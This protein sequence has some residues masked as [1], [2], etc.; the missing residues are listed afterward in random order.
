M[1]AACCPQGGGGGGAAAASSVAEVKQVAGGG[2]SVGTG[3]VA[4]HKCDKLWQIV[5]I[6]CLNAVPSSWLE[7]GFSSGRLDT[8]SMPTL[9]C[10]LMHAFLQLGI[11]VRYDPVTFFGHRHKD[12]G[13][14]SDFAIFD[15][16][17][18]QVGLDP[19]MVQAGTAMRCG[20]HRKWRTSASLV[21]ARF[22]WT[23]NRWFPSSSQVTQV[24]VLSK[25]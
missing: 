14:V 8:F 20:V 21:N 25:G 17:V 13:S 9:D 23:A 19:G 10:P 24:P 18:W 3:L 1:P 16:A 22:L 4:M 12:H 7:W 11:I 2:N 5:T 6:G 15:F